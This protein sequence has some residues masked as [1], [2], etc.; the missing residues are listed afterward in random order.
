MASGG[1]YALEFHFPTFLTQIHFERCILMSSPKILA[2]VIGSIALLAS[3]CVAQDSGFQALDKD[4][5]GKVSVAEF[6]S[7]ASGKLPGFDKLEQFATKVDGDGNGEISES[8]FENRMQFLE[9]LSEN[10][11]DDT[12][13]KEGKKQNQE[14][15]K[16]AKAAFQK[17]QKLIGKGEWESAS[18]MMSEKAQKEV[19]I[20]QVLSAIGRLGK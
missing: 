20:E 9:A 8:E 5:D 10:S 1:D 18:K 6:K 16:E 7:Y 11:S 13:E 3:H 4:S 12:K 2:L 14:A 19:V 17:I 15:P